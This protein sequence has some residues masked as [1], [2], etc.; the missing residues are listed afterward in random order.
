M[1]TSAEQTNDSISSIHRYIKA[2]VIANVWVGSI[3]NR[4]EGGYGDGERIVGVP[5]SSQSTALF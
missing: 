1:A 5:L 4:D 3:D 2:G